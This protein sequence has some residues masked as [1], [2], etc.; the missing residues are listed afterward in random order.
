MSRNIRN[1]AHPS[2]PP[3][4]QFRQP[5]MPTSNQKLDFIAIRRIPI[6][7]SQTSAHTRTKQTVFLADLAIDSPHLPKP[8]KLSFA[9][10]RVPSRINAFPANANKP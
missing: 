5:P 3:K 10:L 8:Q 2:N 4:S 1:P 7:S 6:E 9:K